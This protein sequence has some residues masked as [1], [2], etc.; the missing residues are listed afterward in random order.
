MRALSRTLSVMLEV[1]PDQIVPINDRDRYD[2]IPQHWPSFVGKTLQ[3][4]ENN[5]LRSKPLTKN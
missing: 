4:E 3:T 5:A 2:F 1:D